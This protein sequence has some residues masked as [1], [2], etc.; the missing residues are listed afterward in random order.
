[1]IANSSQPLHIVLFLGFDLHKI[2]NLLKTLDDTYK[3]VI[4]D[5]TDSGRP[6][7]ESLYKIYKDKLTFYEGCVATNVNKYIEKHTSVSGP[8]FDTSYT[9][10]GN[11]ELL[12][13]CKVNND[14]DIHLECG[15]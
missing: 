4:F 1:M 15:L 11:L 10:E 2:T 14:V 5:V 8:V 6:Q 13:T 7:F 12:N 9:F 3:I